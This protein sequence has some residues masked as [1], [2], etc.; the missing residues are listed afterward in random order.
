MWETNMGYD[1]QVG[2]VP[3]MQSWNGLKQ[4][5]R[6]GL[7]IYFYESRQAKHGRHEIVFGWRQIPSDTGE[8]PTHFL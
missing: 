6:H 2:L 3:S 1:D 4:A 7:T 8:S 5:L